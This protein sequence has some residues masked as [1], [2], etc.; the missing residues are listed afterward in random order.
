MPKFEK[1]GSDTPFAEP[2]W[3]RGIPTPYFQEK[4]AKWRAH[5]REFVEKEIQPFADKWDESYSFPVEELRKKAY[6]AGVLSP[7][8]PPEL[9]GTPPEGGWDKW[10]DLI[11]NDEMSRSGA[12]GINIILYGITQMSL[13]HTLRYGSKWLKETV[14][15]PVIKGDCGMSITLTEPQGGS[16]LA[17][18][19]S[20]AV[21]TPCGKFYIVNGIKKFITGAMTSA[22]FSTLVRTGGAMH[23]G[24]SLLVIP[25]DLPG[26]TCKKLITQGWWAGNTATVI[27][28]DVK[29]PVEYL[30]GREGMG[31]PMMVDVM[32]H[33]R[34]VGI[35]GCTRSSREMVRIS[36][37]YARERTTF[38]KRLIDHQVIRHKIAHMIKN[39][40][41]CQ[42]SLEALTYQLENGARATEVGGTIALAK[43][44]STQ[45]LELCCR[46]ASQILGGNSYLRQGKGQLV[47]R[48][49]RE[50]RVTAVGGGS[51]E[52]MIDLA[53][54]QA[55]L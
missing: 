6:A 19:E 8:F 34:M 52:V 43:V 27:F 2:A 55:K 30:V 9:G 17:R 26:V 32:N 18:L 37:E 23:A 31:F 28:E 20:T 35:I 3:Y 47:E 42:D 22:Y 48:A 40:E 45:T 21:K 50:V 44:R 53:M 49:S 12:G 5:V 33:E 25:K 16:D 14:A 11:W 46:E 4:H 13:P 7:M 24:V 51:E 41:A 29:V 54:R 38:G 15:V 1:F 36:I 39:V 10:M